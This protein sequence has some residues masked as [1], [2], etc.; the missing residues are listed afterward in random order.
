LAI[1]FSRTTRALE[2][3][4]FGVA[5]LLWLLGGVLLAAWMAWFLWASVAVFAVSAAARLE[6]VRSSSPI[7]VMTS[8]KILS[9][10]LALG[11][12][13]NVGEVLLTL[14]ATS[15]QMRLQEE[16][17]RQQA[18]PTQINALQK[19]IIALEQAKSV[20]QQAQ[21]ASV[22]SAKSRQSEAHSAFTFAEDHARRL[23][24]LS[25]QGQM[26]L[27]DSL[28][29]QTEM[30]KLLANKNALTADMQRVQKTAETQLHQ[31]QADI[32]HLKSEIAKL[33]GELNSSLSASVR[34][35][36]TIDN[37]QVRAPI[38]G[39]IGDALPLQIGTYVNLGDK[40]G[41]IIPDGEL[42]IVAD[43]PPAAVI[44][45]IHPGQSATMRLD[46]FPW[47]QYGVVPAV[48]SQVGAE[49]RNAQ[50]RVE[51]TPQ[52]PSAAALQLQH[53]LPGSIAVQIEHVSPAILVL[54]ASGQ[55][56]SNH[57][58][59]GLAR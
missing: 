6:V 28:K 27:M 2:Q 12:E 11:Q 49:I 3:D 34:L 20:A 25:A 7:T 37:H 19:Q 29:A 17:A 31:Q 24:E 8:G 5:L 43:F 22:Q 35:Q 40:L 32:E 53:G 56:L 51:F 46:G 21:L 48:V 15:D 33:Q 9:S 23:A 38:A 47:A 26:P 14:D 30:Q 18:L 4:T 50:V 41:A 1:S 44:G 58:S 36:Q 54:R 59:T 39:R 10:K 57:L 16:R 55:L 52:L 42:R 45:K 13:V